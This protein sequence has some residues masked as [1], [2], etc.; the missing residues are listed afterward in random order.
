MSRLCL[1]TVRWSAP[2]GAGAM[3]EGP[4]AAVAPAPPPRCHYYGCLAL[5]VEMMKSVVCQRPPSGGMERQA[6]WAVRAERN[7]LACGPF[8]ARGGQRP[9]LW[10][11]QGVCVVECAASPCSLGV[12]GCARCGRAVEYLFDTVVDGKRHIVSAHALG[13]A[14]RP[15]RLARLES[16]PELVIL[17]PSLLARAAAS[18]RRARAQ[19]DF[20]PHERVKGAMFST[21]ARPIEVGFESPPRQGA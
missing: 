20:P 4:P 14:A 11:E 21:T 16:S 12:R 19:A 5:V 17:G 6:D 7:C 15:G 10:D 18:A 1:R 8:D 3:V 13:V 9:V 2:V